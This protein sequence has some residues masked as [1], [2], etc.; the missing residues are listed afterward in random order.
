LDRTTRRVQRIASL[1][2]EAVVIDAVNTGR[3]IE[4]AVVDARA[5]A[6]AIGP[7]ARAT[8]MPS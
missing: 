1:P 3:K 5:E 2:I 6:R 8:L 7:F 4:R